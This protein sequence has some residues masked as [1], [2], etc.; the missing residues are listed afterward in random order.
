MI[1]YT[2]NHKDATKTLPE[3]TELNKVTDYKDNAQ[4]QILFLRE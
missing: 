3:L 1:V 4:K 2:E